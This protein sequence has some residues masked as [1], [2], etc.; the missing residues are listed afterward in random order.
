MKKSGSF[1]QLAQSATIAAMYVALTYLSHFMGLSS[2][3]IQLRFSEAL[4]ILPLFTPAALPGLTVG[5]LLANL[6][7]GCALWDVLF[8]S[9]A[10]LLGALGTR[11]L[12]GKRLHFAPLYPIFSNA[13]IVP[14]ILQYVYGMPK[15][16]WYLVF[17]VG[18]GQVLSCGILGIALGSLI[19][20]IGPGR[21]FLQ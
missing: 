18:T 14:L 15:G 19:Q 4:T 2:G 11:Y 6:L 1:L 17:T 12:C 20:R 13:L 7:T 21:L 10:T 9:L 5:C 3:G 8:G 16:Y